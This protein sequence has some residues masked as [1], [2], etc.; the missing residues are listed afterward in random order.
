M[1]TPEV[2]PPA[3]SR[4]ASRW[5]LLDAIGSLL[6]FLVLSL[7]AGFVLIGFG[8][9][10]VTAGIIGTP[11]GWLALGGWPW[12]A[13]TRRGDGMRTDLDFT[14]RPI[15]AVYGIAAAGALFVVALFFIALYVTLVGE[16]PSS[17]IGDMAEASTADWQ[18]LLLVALAL[19][20]AVVEE[21]HF[22]GLW[23]NA[24]RR[25][26]VRPWPTLLITSAA[27][28]LTHLELTRAPLLFVIGLA[29]GFVRMR[30]GRL[31]TAI[32]AHVIINGA[33]SL[34]LLTML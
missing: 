30:T 24:L 18:I 17:T 28:S 20:A 7:V 32:A 8:V 6:G 1:T 26:R 13:T 16:D 31:G 15:D 10:P 4:S 22:R 12:L 14:F 2:A 34:G 5:G 21:V 3:A 19:G 29:I 9:D 23:W 11:V 27:F 33:G 25:R